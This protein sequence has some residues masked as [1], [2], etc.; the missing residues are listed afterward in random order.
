MVPGKIENWAIIIDL[1]HKSLMRIPMRELKKI[2]EVLQNNYTCRMAYTFI[3][4]AP[5][6]LRFIWGLV[7]SFLDSQSVEKIRIHSEGNPGELLERV[8]PE[9]LEEKYGGVNENLNEFWPSVVPLEKTKSAVYQEEYK[10]TGESSEESMGKVA[11]ESSRPK[12]GE[13]S[14]QTSSGN[15]MVI[16]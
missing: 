1:S 15:C 14:L 5:S 9:Q 4:N 3:V 16:M 11:P 2:L 13:D 7:S 8:S 6:S 10:G 12:E